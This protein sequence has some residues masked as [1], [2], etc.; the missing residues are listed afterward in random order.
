MFCPNCKYEYNVGVLVC[1]DCE[2]KLV[3]K[4]T[5]E[6]NEPSID[7]SKTMVVFQASDR[8]LINGVKSILEENGI[9]CFLKPPL[10]LRSHTGPVQVVISESDL[11]KARELLDGIE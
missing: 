1:P 6:E 2:A 10:V 9:I 5:V 4:L 7:E 11:P 3:E 8:S